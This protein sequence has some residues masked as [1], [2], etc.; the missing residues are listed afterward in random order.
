LIP[1][2]HFRPEPSLPVLRRLI[3]D[4]ATEVWPLE[5]GKTVDR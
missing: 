1:L 5:P 4:A 2:E 3:A